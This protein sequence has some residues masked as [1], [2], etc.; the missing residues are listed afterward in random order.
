MCSWHIVDN[1][2]KL[3][4][5]INKKSCKKIPWLCLNVWFIFRFGNEI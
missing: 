3:R 5:K 1:F 4:A 2:R